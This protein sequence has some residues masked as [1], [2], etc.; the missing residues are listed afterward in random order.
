MKRIN[1][2][3]LQ[4]DSKAK[5]V[6]VYTLV[7]REINYRKADEYEQLMKRNCTRCRA[8]QEVEYDE[9]KVTQCHWIGIIRDECANVDALHICRFFEKNLQ[10]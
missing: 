10:K 2:A 9:E 6:N 3:Q 8:V 4:K 5:R 1:I 7:K